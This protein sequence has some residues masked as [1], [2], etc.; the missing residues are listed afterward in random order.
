[1]FVFSTRHAS[2]KSAGYTSCKSSRLRTPSAK[3]R[4]AFSTHTREYLELSFR[5]NPAPTKFQCMEIKEKTELSYEQVRTWVCIFR[6]KIDQLL[7]ATITNYSLITNEE[8]R[9]KM[10]AVILYMAIIV[11][12]Q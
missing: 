11:L 3:K 7:Y 4:P 9:K 6:R 2:T 1:M 10:K 5:A 8:E 12:F